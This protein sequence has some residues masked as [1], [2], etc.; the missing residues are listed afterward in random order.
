M[1]KA[2][3]VSI[4]KLKPGQIV[5][6]RESDYVFLGCKWRRPNGY[7]IRIIRPGDVADTTAGHY[8][9]GGGIRITKPKATPLQL[10]LVGEH[11]K[12]AI[13]KLLE[14]IGERR[15]KEYKRQTKAFDNRRHGRSPGEDTYKLANGQTIGL[16]SEVIVRFS[17]GDFSCLVVGQGGENAER[18]RLLNKKALIGVL[19]ITYGGY[20]SRPQYVAPTA[21][22]K[23]IKMGDLQSL[24]NNEIF[25]DMM[26][27][28]NTK[29]DRARNTREHRYVLRAKFGYL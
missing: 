23:L 15:S 10:P 7:S 27:N 9:R 13:K 19:D 12:A 14:A 5:T 3:L 18:R 4:H 20:R 11:P 26:R 28:Q 16:G 8:I 1:A 17:N 6:W 24:E 21:I 29:A 22:I 25:Q 2:K